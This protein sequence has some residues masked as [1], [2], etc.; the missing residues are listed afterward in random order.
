MQRLVQS[1][2]S[3]RFHFHMVSRQPPTLL[4][5]R[6]DSAFANVNLWGRWGDI[7]QTFVHNNTRRPA[8]APV[9]RAVD[10]AVICATDDKQQPP[11]W[12][13]NTQSAGCRRSMLTGTS[14]RGDEPMTYFS[15]TEEVRAVIRIMQK[16]GKASECRTGWCWRTRSANIKPTCYIR[17]YR[18]AISGTSPY[19]ESIE[20]STK[21]IWDK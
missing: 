16:T 13:R 10:A 12:T 17:N 18:Y 3:E 2:F 5:V 14:T 6:V 11:T 21:G 4:P 9:S 15:R 19:G 7:A 20:R 8:S 1:P